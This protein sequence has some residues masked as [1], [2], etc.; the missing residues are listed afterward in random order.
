M[1]VE[2][3]ELPF[4]TVVSRLWD[5]NFRLRTCTSQLVFC[6][7]GHVTFVSGLFRKLFAGTP[8]HNLAFQNICRRT[9]GFKT[10]RFSTSGM[11]KTSEN[12]YGFKHPSRDALGK[13][14]TCGIPSTNQQKQ[15]P[16]PDHL[17]QQINKATTT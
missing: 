1:V 9:Q 15:R 16:Q 12:T 17:Q 5:H 2:V 13:Q 11:A 10:F 8:F 7:I 4:K 6:T 14:I 3:S